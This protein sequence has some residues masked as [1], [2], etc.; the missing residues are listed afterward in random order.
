MGSNDFGRALAD[1]NAVLAIN[2]SDANAYAFRGSIYADM[3]D[4]QR[5][6]KEVNTAIKLNPK[7]SIA[8][9]NLGAIYNK[10]QQYDK[11]IEAYDKALQLFPIGTFGMYFGRGYSHLNLGENDQALADFNKSLAINPNYGF[12]LVNRGRIYTESGDYDLALKDLNK[13]SLQFPNG[14]N[15]LLYRAR[16]Y[17]LSRNFTAARDDFQRVLDLS[18]SHGVA[19]AGLERIEAKISIANGT[20]RPDPN[21]SSVRTALVIGNSRYVSVGKLTNPERDAMLLAD[22]F[23]RLGFEKVQLVIDGSHDAIATA[24]KTFAETA[25]KSDWAVVYFAGH[26][27]EFDGSNYLVPVDVR[28]ERDDD[29]PKESIALDQVLNAVGGAGKLRLVILDACRENPFVADMK[30]SDA[31]TV[32]RGLA[33]IEPGVR[34]RWLPLRHK[35]GQTASDGSSQN[36]PFA[37][38]LVGRMLTPGL[39]VNQLFRL[40]HDEVLVATN[41][42]QEPFTYGQ[43]PAEQFYFWK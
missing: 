2:P 11:A 28:Y 7:F 41:K 23:Q 5:G 10:L 30:R 29:I 25:A 8:Y 4:P 38:A 20:V 16:V 21:R 9:G 36:S 3:G 15:T 42:E 14:M 1:Y 17:E 33:R 18:P 40:V 22:G 31:S 43:L 37:T 39:E 27:I 12:A 13:A 26:G 24:L 34:A 32:G 6:L 19:E 35:H